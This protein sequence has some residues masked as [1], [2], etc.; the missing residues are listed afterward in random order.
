VSFSLSLL[1]SLYSLS[2][3]HSLRPSFGG[4]IIRSSWCLGNAVGLAAVGGQGSSCASKGNFV[5]VI[6]LNFIYASFHVI[7]I[8]IS[9]GLVNEHFPAD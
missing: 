7:I 9:L 5:I 3:L 4:V 2:F 1:H 8:I 6:N